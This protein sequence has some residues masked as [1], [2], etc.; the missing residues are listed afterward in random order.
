M[1]KKEISFLGVFSI[2]SGAMISSGIFILPGIAFSKVGPA[3]FVSY[4]IAGVLGLIGIFSVIELSTAMPKA[5]GDYFFINKTFGPF[6]GTISGFL[7]WFALSLKSAFAIFGISE[8]IFL[9]TG[10]NPIIAGFILCLF[11]VFL[12]LIGVKEAAIFQIIMVV[13]L[14]SLIILFIIIGLQKIQPS[15]FIPFYTGN[16]NNIVITSG[17]VFISFGGL[18]NVANI[19]EEVKNPQRNI[20]LGMITSIIVVTLLYT[21]ITYVITGTLNPMVFKDSLTPV[22]DSAKLIMGTAGYIIIIIASLLAFFTTANAGIMSASRYPLALSRDQ[23]LPKKIALISKKFK[24]PTISII[25]TGI[26]IYL[27]L[28]LPLEMLVKAASTVILTS[29]VLT[30]LSV[31]IL[32]ESKIINYKPSFKA[33][34]YPWLQIVCVILFTFF[35]IDLGIAAIELSLAL[36]FISFC[37]YIFY[38]RKL[39]NSEYALLYLLKRIT[40]R[41]LTENIIEDELREILIN[42]DNVEQDNFDQLIKNAKIIDIDEFMDFENLLKK[43]AK[44]L[45]KEIEM[46]EEEIT[47]RFIKRQQESNTALSDFLAL[48]HIIIDGEDKMFLRIIRAKKGIKFTEKENK[49][50]AIFLLGGTKEKRVLHLK[51]L[52]SIATLVGLKDFQEKWLSVDNI[53]EI[54]NLMILS[55][56]KRFY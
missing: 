5:G 10:I 18:L 43:V 25:I 7:G 11:F 49:I 1:L 14:L 42:R 55:N 29:Y 54:K 34:F 23:L 36:L 12:N 32:R 20:P 8:V 6:L 26:I 46:T 15:H 3:V 48:P 50:K 52:A 21:F 45:S 51:T 2:A 22:A 38:G 33:P 31:I 13:G 4:F 39:K 9:Y 41:R 28:L 53:I 17:F 56:R 30:N 44:S 27:T 40:D 16:I 37:I 47:S 19:S 35:I 24:T